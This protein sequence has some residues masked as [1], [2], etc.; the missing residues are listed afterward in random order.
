[1]RSYA[2]RPLP[3]ADETP[4]PRPVACLHRRRVQAGAVV[5]HRQQ[6]GISL[7]PKLEGDRA[8]GGVPERVG[9]RLRGDPSQLFLDVGIQYHRIAGLFQLEAHAGRRR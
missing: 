5:L 4:V 1:M 7:V 2:L 3:H 8:T 9:Q 6:E